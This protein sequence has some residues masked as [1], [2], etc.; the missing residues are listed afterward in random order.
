M[1][2]SAEVNRNLRLAIERRKAALYALSQRY[3]AQMEAHAKINAG[4]QDRTSM[5]RRGLF[6]YSMQR[7]QSLITR[8]AH[9]MDYGVYLELSNH[10][11]YA[12][13]L[14]TVKRFVADF[15][16]DAQKVVAR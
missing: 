5:A 7:D 16:E 6:G 9:T 13:L 15:I 2:G 12:I 1:A 8:I 10:G 14:P 11:K 4:W 3:A